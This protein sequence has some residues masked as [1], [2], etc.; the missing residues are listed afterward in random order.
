M[1]GVPTTGEAPT[2]SA[3]QTWLDRNVNGSIDGFLSFITQG[4]SFRGEAGS[5]CFIL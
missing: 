3:C 5:S 4:A 2:D 1:V